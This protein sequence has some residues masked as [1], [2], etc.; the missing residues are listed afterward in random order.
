MGHNFVII[1]LPNLFFISLYGINIDVIHLLV[2]FEHWCHAHRLNTNVICQFM[3]FRH[4]CCM[5]I[6]VVYTWKPCTQLPCPNNAWHS[7]LNN[8]NLW[9]NIFCSNLEWTHSDN[10]NQNN[11]THGVYILL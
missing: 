6:R 8:T 7:C 10:S 4:K 11:W 5:F 2:L 3:L 9:N 1:V